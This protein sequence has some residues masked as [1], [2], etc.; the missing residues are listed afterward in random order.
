M[1]SVTPLDAEALTVALCVAPGVYSRNRHDALFARP[2]ARRA[3]SR[4]SVLR[5]LVYQL[6]GRSGYVADLVLRRADDGWELRFRIP[7]VCFERRVRL[8]ELEAACV[9][10]LGARSG[11]ASPWQSTEEH[12]QRIERVLATMADVAGV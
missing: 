4:A 7:P 5:G 2:E 3:R 6:A 8:T 9:A 12:R 11:L 1:S 10:Y